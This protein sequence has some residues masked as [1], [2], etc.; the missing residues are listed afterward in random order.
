MMLPQRLFHINVRAFLTFLMQ[1][2]D[3]LDR[4]AFWSPGRLP[5]CALRQRGDGGMH[6][7]SNKMDIVPG[8]V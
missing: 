6:L 4:R 5:S 1:H 3:S 8:G 7:F 2:G